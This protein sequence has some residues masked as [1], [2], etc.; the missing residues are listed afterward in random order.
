MK[1]NTKLSLFGFSAS[2]PPSRGFRESFG[3]ETTLLRWK[4]ASCHTPLK[5]CRVESV[6][7]AAFN[8][9]CAWLEPSMARS[10]ET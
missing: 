4:A 6:R 8:S 3:K 10:S 9:H 2:F 7:R 5:Q 1:V